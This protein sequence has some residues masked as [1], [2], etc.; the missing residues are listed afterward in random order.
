[1]TADSERIRTGGTQ[2]KMEFHMITNV[3][4]HIDTF[5]R[6]T[7]CLLLYYNSIKLP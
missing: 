2:S 4:Y 7:Y 3:T 5:S 6:P 1:M